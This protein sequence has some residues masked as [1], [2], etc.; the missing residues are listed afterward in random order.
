MVL[1]ASA[2]G[3]GSLLASHAM[4]GPVRGEL[5]L[6]ERAL[7]E[8]EGPP[9][10]YWNAWNGFLE[11]K[12]RK[13]SPAREL[14]VVLTGSGGATPIGCNYRITGGDLQ[15]R[16]IVTKGGAGLRI[17]NRDG[18]THELQSEGIEGFAPLATAPGNARQVTVPSG[19]PHEITDRLYGHIHG[20]VV[21]VDDLVACATIEEDG[22]Y[23]FESVPAGEYTL[24]VYRDGEEVT[25][26]AVTVG[27]GPLTVDPLTLE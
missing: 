26:Q 25:T 20:W 8:P 9:P 12:E 1:V 10:Y 4:A 22:K 15:P 23:A 7:P 14:A 17:E 24:K 6:G 2:I 18:C 11:P 13:W 21:G 5:R 16:T 3:G 27:D 19:G